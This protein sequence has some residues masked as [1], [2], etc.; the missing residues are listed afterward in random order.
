MVLWFS[1]QSQT[2]ALKAQNHYSVS[3]TY[4]LKIYT[5]TYQHMRLYIADNFHSNVDLSNFCHS[6]IFSV[7][8]LET[9]SPT[10]FDVQ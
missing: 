8:N 1:L 10:A 4:N 5:A 6:K 7:C 9:E 2:L 3:V